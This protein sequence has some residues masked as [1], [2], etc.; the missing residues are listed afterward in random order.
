MADQAK[1]RAM[2]ERL[3][4]EIRGQHAKGETS[5]VE[6]AIVAATADGLDADLDV[7]RAIIEY[8]E[9]DVAEPY[10][11]ELGTLQ[12]LIDSA[13]APPPAPPRKR[14][15]KLTPAAVEAKKAKAEQPRKNAWGGRTFTVPSSLRF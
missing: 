10:Q 6:Y 4:Q 8:P 5:N 9:L 12:E 14:R 15:K 7:I 3:G 11:E 13:P 2:L 1:I